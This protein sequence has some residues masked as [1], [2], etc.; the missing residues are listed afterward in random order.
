MIRKDFRRNFAARHPLFRLQHSDSGVRWDRSAYYLWWEFLRRHEGYAKTCSKAG[1][2]QFAKLYKD[3]GDVHASDF[4][5]WW[6]TDAR[7]MRLFSEPP[8]PV[9]VMALGDADMLALVE[10]GRDARTLVVAIPLDY[11]R[12]A[13]TQAF[14]KLLTQHFTRKRG[15]KRVHESKARYPLS[16]VPDTVALATTLKCFDLHKSNPDKPL[17]WIAQEA[18]VSAR[19]T[20]AELAGKGG[21]TVSKKASMTAGVSRKLKHAAAIIDGVGRGVFPIR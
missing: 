9:G 8:A 18:G 2:G 14:N 11:R 7:G 15:N 19:L 10:Q 3:F 12:R 6:T 16:K 21:S 4:K 1:K 17:W 13:I 5:T 20:A